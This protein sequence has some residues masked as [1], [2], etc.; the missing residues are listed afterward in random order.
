MTVANLTMSV[1]LS[2]K[3]NLFGTDDVQLCAAW[4]S[5]NRMAPIG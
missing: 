3:L 5:R 1:L 2:F 4:P